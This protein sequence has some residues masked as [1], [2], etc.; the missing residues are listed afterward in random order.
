MRPLLGECRRLVQRGSRALARAVGGGNRRALVSVGGTHAGNGRSV[1][2]S[3]AA[4]RGALARAL[5]V[6]PEAR[7][8]PCGSGQ[9]GTQRDHPLGS[10]GISRG[11]TEKCPEPGGARWRNQ[12]AHGGGR[13]LGVGAGDG[14]IRTAAWGLGRRHHSESACQAARG[15]AQ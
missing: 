15:W 4:A 7:G 3:C 9:A 5:D 10:R 11:W 13:A 8:V 1:L 12:G 14:V 6:V 2:R